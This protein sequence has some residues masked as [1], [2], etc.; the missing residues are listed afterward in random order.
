MKHR[1]NNHFNKN[2]ASKQGGSAFF[3]SKRENQEQSEKQYYNSLNQAKFKRPGRSIH[4]KLY[5]PDKDKESQEFTYMLLIKNYEELTK[6]KT[7]LKFLSK[8]PDIRSSITNKSNLKYTAF[9][10]TKKDVES[11]R[12][13]YAYHGWSTS[14]PK[15]IRNTIININVKVSF[16]NKKIKIIPDRKI[17]P[18]DNTGPSISFSPKT[19]AVVYGGTYGS[20]GMNS[21]KDHFVDL[22]NDDNPIEFNLKQI[23]K[24][25]N[26]NI[27][28]PLYIKK[29]Q[30]HGQH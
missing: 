24:N 16:T 5:G 1:T 20:Y 28:E 8:K 26:Q 6:F 22:T 29:E 30:Q 18:P 2:R 14:I 3:S 19:S 4:R 12:D 13:M 23:L 11:V 10:I 27:K 21:Y 15:I 25:I 17:K 9:E 7:F